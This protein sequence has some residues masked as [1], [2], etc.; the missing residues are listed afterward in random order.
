M[1]KKTE[2][3]SIVFRHLLKCNK[4]FKQISANMDEGVN[5]KAKALVLTLLSVLFI[6]QFV[7]CAHASGKT[8]FRLESAGRDICDLEVHILRDSD[9]W[10][11]GEKRQISI[12]F[13]V[14]NSN[15]SVERLN[16][17]V[18]YIRISLIYN[19]ENYA[20][21]YSYDVVEEDYV[22]SSFMPK[23]VDTTFTTSREF[24]FTVDL[25]ENLFG[26]PPIDSPQDN[27]YTL[28]YSVTLNADWTGGQT[29][30]IGISNS[31]KGFHSGAGANLIENPDVITI[32]PNENSFP[33][34]YVI[35]A[36]VAIGVGIAGASAFLIVKRR[37]L[38]NS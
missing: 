22:G 12:V 30:S 32:I 19:Y 38:K 34:L 35:I 4:F 8:T 17:R 3:S 36:V 10:R 16:L 24:P 20:N 33:L 28:I 2:L 1:L 27:V 5:L 29:D 11:S 18:E 7:L 37:K 6:G 13:E 31:A 26:T 14:K 23:N 25:K 15:P 21:G 9:T